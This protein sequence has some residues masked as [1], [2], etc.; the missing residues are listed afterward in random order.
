[1]SASSGG[2]R[3]MTSDPEM[4]PL[5]AERWKRIEAIFHLAIQTQ[6]QD[7]S[8]FVRRSCNGD[9]LLFAE[10]QRILAAFDDEGKSPS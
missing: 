7:R 5:T 6:G 1:M 10:L 8:E 3:K 2:E 9:E 4:L